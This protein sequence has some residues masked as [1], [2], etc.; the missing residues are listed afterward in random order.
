M[1]QAARL[2]STPP[3]NTP[4]KRHDEAGNMTLNPEQGTLGDLE[5]PICDLV[6][7]AEVCDTLLQN[8]QK[9][10]LSAADEN[11]SSKLTL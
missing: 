3:I 2:H 10:A 9:E 4:S 6:D 11:V 7:M 1:T 5:S 8:Y